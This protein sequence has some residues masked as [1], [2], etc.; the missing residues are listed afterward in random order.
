M[1]KTQSTIL[2]FILSISLLCV[3]F[4]IAW[5]LNAASNFLYSTWYEVLSLDSAI[6]KYATDNKFKKGFEH[7]N[8]QQHVE[9]F[10]GIVVGIQ[11]R[12]EGLRKL[13]Y[14]DKNNGIKQTLL[15][16]AELVHLEDVAK[17][18]SIFKY[19]AI[20]GSFIAFIVFLIM[21]FKNILIAKYKRHLFGAVGAILSICILVILIGP[22]KIFYFG[23][24]LIFPNNHQWF[25][26]YEE[27]LMS[28]MMKAP[29]LFGPIA[30]QLLISTVVLWLTALYVLQVMQAKFK[31]A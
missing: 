24:E 4:Y 28:T 30:C 13:S 2:N 23:H 9:L 29:V 21:W 11:N 22:T 12:G 17:L 8:K 25:F 14:L 26:Y 6:T 5:N 7:T 27:S 16:D 18:V 31:M 20:F 15:T 3:S 1:D 10:S 19:V